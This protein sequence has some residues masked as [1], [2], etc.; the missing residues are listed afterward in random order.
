MTRR[1]PAILTALLA[2][3]GADARSAPQAGPTLYSGSRLIMGTRCEVEVYHADGPGAEEAIR[4]ALD[5]MDR[6]DRLLSNYRPDSDLSVM[7]RQA[8]T[9]PVR[10]SD[11]LFAF[12]R[13][14]R[15][16]YE[17]SRH[18]FDP[19]IGPLVRAWGF[20]GRQPSRPDPAVA[21]DAKRRS[22]FE[23]VRIDERA[24]TV[25]YDAAGLE[26]DPGGIG[27]GWAADRAADVLRRNGIASALVSAGGSTLVAIGHPPGRDG[28]RV[29]VRDPL[30]ATKPYAYVSLRNAALST[31]GVSEKSVEEGSRRFAHIFDPRTGEPVEHMCQATVVAPT[32]TQ[33]D[34]LTK[35]AFILPR[36]DA[37]EVFGAMRNVHAMRVEGS[38]G[39]GAN[40]WTTPGSSPIFQR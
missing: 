12:V 33:S 22:G 35:P 14:S 36:A 34:A 24:G 10:V 6:V 26:F 20:F 16:F 15:S 1:W 5:E 8:A 30:N 37:A 19:T 29:A 4:A 31:S 28:W 13:A 18:T 38:C 40:V 11:E 25:A 17:Q 23:H 9:R 7:N 39:A 21:A 2:A 32:G 27:K 3:V